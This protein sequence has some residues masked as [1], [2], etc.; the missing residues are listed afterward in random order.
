MTLKK[1]ND[2]TPILEYPPDTITDGAKTVTTA[3]TA[4]TLVAASTPAKIVILTALTGN[5]GI[6]W[7]GGS[8]VAD[9]RGVPLTPRQSVTLQIDDLQKVY[10]DTD[11]STDGVSYVALV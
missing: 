9:G 3:G 11:N 7:I 4:E 5:A 8:T 10:L 2:E 1:R 6:M